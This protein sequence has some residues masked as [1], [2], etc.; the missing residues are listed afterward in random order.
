[1]GNIMRVLKRDVLRLFKAP[2]ALV[3][4]AV[5]V[6]LPS[7]YTWFNVAGFWD[8][9]NNTGNLRVCVVNEDTGATTDLTGSLNLGDQI[10]EEL[11]SNT[12]LGWTR[13]DRATAMEEVESGKAYAAFVIPENFSQNLASLLT[14]DFQQPQLEYYVN[15]KAGA[16]SPKITDTGA[17]TL[18]ET[19]NSTFVSTVSSVIADTVDTKLA[20]SQADIDASKANVALQFQK[21]KTTITDARATVAGLTEAA[22]GALAKTSEAQASL[23]D[24]KADITLLSTQLQQVSTLT[25]VTQN[26]LG[27]F[28]AGMMPVMDQSSILASQSAARTNASIGSAAGAVVEAQGEVGAALKSGQAAADQNA[29]IIEQL[30]AMLKVLPDSD[31]NKE[32]LVQAIASL[33]SQNADLKQALAGMETISQDTGNAAASIAGASDSVNTAVQGMLGSATE[34]RSTLSSTTLPAINTGLSQV[35]GA[36]GG[37]SAA[38]SNQT[39]L[40]DQASLALDQLASTLQTASVALAQTDGLLASLETSLGTVQTDLVALGTSSILTDLFGEEGLDTSKIA[41]FMQSPTEVKTETM[42]ALNAYGSAMAPLFMNLT[43]WIGVFMLMVILRQEVDDEGIKNLTTT[44]RYWARWLFLAP[45]VALQAAVCCTGNLVMGVQAASVPLFYLTAIVA[46]LT[47]LSIQFALSLTLQHI[48]K[49]ICVVL[50]FVQ[51]PGATGLYPI[52]MTPP[53]FQAVYPFFPFTYG[54]NAMRETIAGFYDGQWGSLMAVLLVFLVVSFVIGLLVRPYMTNLN[55]LFAKQIRQS[56]ILNG[57][58]VQVPARRYRLGQVIRAL[59]D[60][61][62]YRVRLQE[63][64]D[65]FIRWYPH[66]K[67]GAWFFGVVVPAVVAVAFSLTGS[68]KVIELTLWLGW[69]VFVLMFLVVIEHIRDSLERQLSFE[70]LSDD[71]LRSLIFEPRDLKKVSLL[72]KSG[73][74]STSLPN[75]SKVGTAPL[76]DVDDT[77]EGSKA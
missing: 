69:L 72:D 75:S 25:V 40:V 4:V 30:K 54:I 13:T 14:G 64:A 3:V 37:L 33:E 12:Q 18:D 51:I 39:L 21:A 6:I 36:A 55:R 29:V 57:E 42:Y 56:D 24:A 28:V 50:V 43:L 1:M 63:H 58:D 59:S 44:Q 31:P 19:I 5:L 73:L 11:D 35:G 20:E 71:E 70:T 22:Q 16:V 66:L 48:G 62:E 61:E 41:D 23:R 53:F 32:L 34:Y 45:L 2:A 9:Y 17:T 68:E 60:R 38:V 77:D 47:Y 76:P 26:S 67:H 52:E 7:L 74:K 46:S 8:P 10:M 27:S 15:E 49:G 65:R